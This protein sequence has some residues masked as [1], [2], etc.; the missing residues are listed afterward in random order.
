MRKKNRKPSAIFII[1]CIILIFGLAPGIVLNAYSCSAARKVRSLLSPSAPIDVLPQE[2]TLTIDGDTATFT[3]GSDSYRSLL[4]LLRLIRSED[5]VRQAGPHPYTHG[6]RCGELVIR[7]LGV[8]FHCRLYRST[9]NA[10]YIAISIPY[11]NN[12][13]GSA[14]PWLLDNNKLG[15][16]VRSQLAAI[17]TDKKTTTEGEQG[18][19]EERR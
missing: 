15:M 16:L 2:V 11:G 14:F 7:P 13:P 17:Y 1:I 18:G 5:A 19:G 10:N 3:K 4:S 12:R 6:P 9:D 8:P